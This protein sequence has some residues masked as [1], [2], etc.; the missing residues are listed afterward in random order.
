MSHL[1]REPMSALAP[2]LVTLVQAAAEI[3]TSLPLLEEVVAAEEIPSYIVG[4][5][6]V[7]RRSDVL[8]WAALLRS[9]LNLA[10]DRGAGAGAPLIEPPDSPLAERRPIRHE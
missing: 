8:M 5:T 3:Q 1:I 4:G 7:V 2:D 10:E 6:R 9:A